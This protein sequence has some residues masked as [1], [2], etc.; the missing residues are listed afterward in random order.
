MK[1]RRI[2]AWI[3]VL[4]LFL[5]ACTEETSAPGGEST[6]PA[7]PSDSSEPTVPT[8]TRGPADLGKEVRFRLGGKRTVHYTVNMSVARYI[9]SPE[10]LPEYGELEEYDDA[11]FADHA[12]LLVYETVRSSSLQVDVERIL[13]EDGRADI[14]LSHTP[15]DTMGTTVY[16]TWLLWLEVDADLEYSW[17]V[18]NPAEDNET[19]DR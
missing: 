3:L 5:A 18:L 16:T 13:L 4:C 15:G 12:L 1:Q 10:K 9:D 19:A 11:W 6:P 14:T 8:V 2:L 7:D 17:N